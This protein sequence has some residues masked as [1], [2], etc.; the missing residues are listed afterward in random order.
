PPPAA[1]LPVRGSLGA[2]R[3][4]AQA[5]DRERGRNDA[6][7]AGAVPAPAGHLLPVV[8]CGFARLGEHLLLV[9]PLE[10]SPFDEDLAVHDDG[11]DVAPGA[12]VDER[13]DGI[14][15]ERAAE[16]VE[17]DEQD[18]GLGALRQPAEVIP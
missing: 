15:V 17:V 7:H 16:V 6:A 4:L 9:G 5:P 10:T 14:G 1:A 11:V 8:A 18:V 2:P 12:G 13:L 3:A